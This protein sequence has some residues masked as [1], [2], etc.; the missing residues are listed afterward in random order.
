ML[1]DAVTYAKKSLE[2]AF[3]LF[4]VITDGLTDEQYN[5][6][7][8][9]TA[10]TIAKSHVHAMS[11]VDFFITATLA[12]GEMAWKP[13][14][15]RSKLPANPTEIWAHAGP[16]PFAPIK[17]YGLT[18]QKAALDYVS[19]LTDADLDRE[20]ETPF[21]GKKNAAFLISLSGVHVMGHGGDIAAVKGLQGLKG[22]PF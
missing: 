6:K 4:N 21:F 14:A 11:S 13:L 16:I 20:V 15:E 2:Q 9:G 22:L 5:W 18:V 12:G 3:G 8:E 17:E 1:M 7:P 19:T 10:N